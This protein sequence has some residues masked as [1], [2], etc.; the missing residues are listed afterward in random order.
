MAR[1][2]KPTAPAPRHDDHAAHIAL[3]NRL[4]AFQ[5][6]LS[7][8]GKSR[9]THEAPAATIDMAADLIGQMSRLMRGAVEARGLPRLADDRPIT[10]SELSIAF[11]QAH[12][13]FGSFGKRMGF[14]KPVPEPPTNQ[15]RNEIVR[16]INV[17]IIVGIRTGYLIPTG[18]EY[19]A[20]KLQLSD[21]FR[22]IVERLGLIVDAEVL[23]DPNEKW[24]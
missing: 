4:T 14:D 8:Q 15:F 21:Q 12:H 16:M 13:A 7:A 20:E 10:F 2:K 22:D 17:R 11:A 1:H 9:A 24:F 5:T 19:D 18:N 6:E 3:T 23:P